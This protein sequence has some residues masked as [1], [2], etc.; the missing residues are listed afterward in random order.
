[1]FPTSAKRSVITNGLSSNGLLLT[2]SSTSA[3]RNIARWPRYCAEQGLVLCC[4]WVRLARNRPDLGRMSRRKKA[5]Q[6]TYNPWS[7]PGCPS[8]GR[9]PQTAWMGSPWWPPGW[10]ALGGLSVFKS[11]SPSPVG[12][13]PRT[14][15]LPGP[16]SS[17]LQHRSSALQHTGAPC[18]IS[19]SS[20]DASVACLAGCHVLQLPF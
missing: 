16:R 17:A 12:R 19:T 14:C 13:V 15:A 5:L 8:V 6:I 9:V 2:G 11:L 10:A 4:W 7:G 3:G 20:P 1:M 18:S